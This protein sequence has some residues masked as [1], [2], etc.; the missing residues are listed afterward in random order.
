MGYGEKGS[1]EGHHL[2]GMRDQRRSLGTGHRSAVSASPAEPLSGREALCVVTV[3]TYNLLEARF[4]AVQ[5][6]DGAS[7]WLVPEPRCTRCF[8]PVKERFAN[9]TG[10]C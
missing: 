10:L 8:L 2:L 1:Q 9:S 3:T 4:R 6:S 7:H 5:R